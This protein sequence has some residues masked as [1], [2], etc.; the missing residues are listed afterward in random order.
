MEGM[1][2]TGIN[3]AY[4]LPSS[5]LY[6]KAYNNKFPESARK[7]IFEKLPFSETSENQ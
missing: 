2:K 6:Q 7:A 4:H 5:D 1:T 3:T